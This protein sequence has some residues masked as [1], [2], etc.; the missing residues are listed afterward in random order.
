MIRKTRMFT[1][2]SRFKDI[3]L[4]RRDQ[5]IR[6]HLA[7]MQNQR[8]RRQKRVKS[9][10]N[11]SDCFKLGAI[12]AL[13]IFILL[14][15]MIEYF[16][17]Y[18]YDWNA[19]HFIIETMVNESQ[20]TAFAFWECFTQGIETNMFDIGYYCV[21]NEQI[22]ILNHEIGRGG[23]GAVYSITINSS[24]YALKHSYAKD[25][26]HHLKREWITLKMI[27]TTD[28]VTDSL[29]PLHHNLSN[30]YYCQEPHP[31]SDLG[32]HCFIIISAINNSITIFDLVEFHEHR[33]DRIT[34]ASIRT[35][36]RK[37]LMHME[38]MTDG[39]KLL[40]FI[41]D[42]YQNVQSVLDALRKEFIYYS[43]ELIHN[44]L[45]N[46]DTNRC[47]LID[48]GLVT[49]MRDN[50]DIMSDT[51]HLDHQRR[52]SPYSVYYLHSPESRKR[53]MKRFS[54]QHQGIK[55][56]QKIAHW[57]TKHKLG[58]F[59]LRIFATFY[60]DVI[61][62]SPYIA[63]LNQSSFDDVEDI[64]NRLYDVGKIRRI[65]PKVFWTLRDT[66]IRLIKTQINDLNAVFDTTLT[67]QFFVMLKDIHTGETMNKP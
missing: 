47:V 26:C 4:L 52:F 51:K 54:F 1:M 66:L 49:E 40:S 35:I 22:I 6:K 53:F 60:M 12:V 28:T 58:A 57:N 20:S 41:L 63:V 33:L 23:Q 56:L 16:A 15:F 10:K 9:S 43:D 7:K 39:N 44:V 45:L 2:S 29:L 34:K 13:S 27:Q 61:R 3:E 46:I 62:E 65:N 55:K 67:K 18:S 19:D 50:I 48:F 24:L 31:V 11:D 8:K 21:L 36:Q 37:H 32:M 30:F 64:K 42:C 17:N 59:A 5:L 38:W 14:I 25:M